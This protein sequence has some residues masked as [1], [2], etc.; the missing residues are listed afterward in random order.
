MREKEI[1]IDIELFFCFISGNDRRK[2]ID[3]FQRDDHSERTNDD[4]V[5]SKF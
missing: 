4:D 3:G 2:K 1:S 5:K